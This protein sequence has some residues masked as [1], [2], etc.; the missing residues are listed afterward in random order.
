LGAQCNCNAIAMTVT[1]MEN[2]A[3]T[4]RTQWLI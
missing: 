4:R 2:L 1:R 3:A